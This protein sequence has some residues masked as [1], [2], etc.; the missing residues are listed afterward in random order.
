MNFSINYSEPA[1]A[2]FREGR[3]KVDFFKCPE[4]PGL[5]TEAARLRPV[6]VH[7]NIKAG[8][9]K[10]A[11]TNWNLVTEWFSKTQ[12]PYVNLHLAPRARAFPGMPIDTTSPAHRAQVTERLIADVSEVT[13]RFGAERVIVENVPYHGLGGKFI[14]P[15]MEPETICQVVEV[16]GCGLLLDISH[17]RIAAHYLDINEQVYLDSLPTRHLRE[18]HFT[19]LE[20]ID[21]KLQDHVPVQN[22]DWPALDFVIERIRSGAWARPWMMAFEYGGIGEKFAHRTDPDVIAA[23]TPRLA[24]LLENV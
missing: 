5:I 15:G 6:A 7:F 4:W 9:D 24:A 13:R 14:R 20:W 17:A 10:L 2:L 8:D 1:A 3:I 22:A 11:A 19:G 12:T 21:G 16:T 18:M 23:Q